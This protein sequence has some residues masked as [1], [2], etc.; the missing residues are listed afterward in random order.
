VREV[1]DGASVKDTATRYGID[2]RTLHRRRAR[3]ANEGFACVCR[4]SKT[5]SPK[6][7]RPR[8]LHRV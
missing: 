7:S 2:R 8:G 4:E 1:L 6:S 3:Y 5:S